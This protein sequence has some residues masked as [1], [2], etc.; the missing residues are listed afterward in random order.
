[1][2]ISHVAVPAGSSTGTVRI[3]DG[4]ASLRGGVTATRLDR[5]GVAA[6]AMRL[7]MPRKMKPWNGSTAS[8]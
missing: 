2:L 5:L 7:A 8:Q 1:M 4:G 3:H 6:A